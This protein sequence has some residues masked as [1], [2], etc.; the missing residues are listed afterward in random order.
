LSKLFC[1][2]FAKLRIAFAYH[3]ISNSSTLHASL[4]DRNDQEGLFLS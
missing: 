2:P 3:F 1:L 4:L